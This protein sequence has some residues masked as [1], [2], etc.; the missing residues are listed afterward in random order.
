VALAGIG[1]LRADAPR[2]FH[3]LLTRGLPLVVL[4]AGFGLVALLR[5]RRLPPRVLQGL[6]AGAAATI[7]LGWGVA[8]Y[9]YVLAPTCRSLS[10]LPR[11]PRCPP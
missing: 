1:I 5:L 4:S 7:V 3:E 8:Q 9:P 10:P 11:S 2:L 6:A